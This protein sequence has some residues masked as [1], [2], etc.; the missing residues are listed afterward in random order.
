[1]ISPLVTI[2]TPTTDDRS[3]MLDRLQEMIRLQDYPHIKW[4]VCYDEFSIGEKRNWL[5]RRAKGEIILH[6][7]SDDLYAYDW[8]SKSVEHLLSSGVNVTGLNSCYF[9]DVSG[10]LYDFTS[11]HQQ[12]YVPEATMC[13]YK[14]AWAKNPFPDSSAGEGMQFLANIGLVKPHNYK[15][16]FVATLHGSNTQSQNAVYMLNKLPLTDAPELLRKYYSF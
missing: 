5:C 6:M 4:L 11:K 9:Y 2:I 1:M 14:S 3:A 10:K 16:G 8:V 13:Y 7:D 15:D 12:P